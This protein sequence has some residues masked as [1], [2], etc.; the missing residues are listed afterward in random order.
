MLTD[1]DWKAKEAELKELMNQKEELS[2][3]IHILKMSLKQHNEYKPKGTK[4]DTEAY[5]MFGKPLSAFTE[6]EKREYYKIRQRINRAKKK[7]NGVNPG[8]YQSAAV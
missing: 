1:K 3:K 8:A 4:T 5:K 6:E 7:E 2:R